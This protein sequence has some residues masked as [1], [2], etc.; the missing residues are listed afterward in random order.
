MEMICSIIFL[1]RIPV[2]RRST[3]RKIQ[4]RGIYPGAK[5]SRGPAWEYGNRDD[6][7]FGTVTKI[8]DWQGNPASAADVSWES[9]TEGTYR[10]GYQGKVSHLNFIVTLSLLFKFVTVI[11]LNRPQSKL[12][13]KTLSSWAYS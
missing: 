3:S 13:Y 6:G 4:A 11:R 7:T 10:L 12:V 1:C 2:E 8:T 9:R 5:V